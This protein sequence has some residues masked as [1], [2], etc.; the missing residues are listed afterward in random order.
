MAR[1]K[2]ISGGQTGVDTAALRLAISLGIPHGGWC[3]RGR[4]RED[5]VIPKRFQLE[6]TPSRGYQQRTAWN[7]RDSDGTVIFSI[8]T[9]LK[10]GSKKTAQ[11]AR[12]RKKPCLHLAQQTGIDH[13]AA[14]RRFVRQHRIR[15]L[16]V[17]GPRKSQEP[18]VGRFVA[19]VMRAAF[20]RN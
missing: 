11:F 7:V 8:A 4:K 1:L 18:A 9:R 10:D 12:Q 19:R 2:V 15:V 17:A 6:E 13:A 5:G 20:S 3:P 14:L 16:N